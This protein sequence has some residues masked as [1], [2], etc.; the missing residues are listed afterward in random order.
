[1]VLYF[2]ICAVLTPA[3]NSLKTGTVRFS[4]YLER[5][6]GFIFRE[7]VIE[8]KVI[9]K[10]E[11]IPQAEWDKVFPSVLEGYHFFK[12]LD[13][14]NF[15]QFQFYYLLVY[16][17]GILVGA[18][19]CFLMNYP[20]DTTVQGVLKN[21]SFAIK[22]VFPNVFNLKALI[23]GLPM[24]RGRIGVLGDPN[25]VIKAIVECMK[26]LADQ[27]KIPIVAFKDFGFEHTNALDQLQKEGFS[28]FESLPTTEKDLHFA[29][30]DEYLKTLSG[31]SRYDLKRKFKKVDGR[32]KIDLEVSSKLN[33]ELDAA[34]DLYLQTEAK[35]DNQF[36]KVPKR[37]FEKVSENMPNQTK[38]FLWHINNKLVAFNY[39]LVSEDYL[40]DCYLGLDYSVAYDYGL[41][42]VKFRDV[43]NWCIKNNIKK[44][45]MGV[46]NYDP[47]KRLGFDFI[48]L[49]VYVKSSNKWISLFFK[50]FGAYLEPANYDPILKEM[51]KNNH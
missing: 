33:G 14:A 11:D 30:F 23:C 42:F 50:N 21:I 7:Q 31:A 4:T 41:Y 22:K 27:E 28:K 29:T 48:P 34:Y 38:Y 37:F 26:Q 45:E 12:S 16:D 2:S 13:Q 8:T 46:S 39:C 49:Y 35:G 19:S 17:N 43:M 6:I 20:L 15:E 5:G 24:G 9:K 18:T 1:V 36:E 25:R 32:V 47:K 10:I 40:L 51:K 44:Y 3:S